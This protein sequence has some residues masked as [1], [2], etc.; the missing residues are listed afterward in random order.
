MKLFLCSIGA[1]IALELTV[2]VLRMSQVPWSPVTVVSALLFIVAVANIVYKP[3]YETTS[4]YTLTI[5]LYLRV[6]LTNP[7]IS[8]CLECL[9]WTRK[10]TVRRIGLQYT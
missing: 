6:K 4:D 2:K 9:Y 8:F 10:S 7:T 1:A 3:S 5:G